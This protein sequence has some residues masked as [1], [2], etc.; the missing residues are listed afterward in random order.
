MDLFFQNNP[1]AYFLR[2]IAYYKYKRKTEKGSY[3]RI[4]FCC[5]SK[6]TFRIS[7]G[8]ICIEF[9]SKL[10]QIRFQNDFRK[11]V[12]AVFEIKNSRSKVITEREADYIISI[13]RYLPS[14]SLSNNHIR[15]SLE[16]IKKVIDEIAKKHEIAITIDE[17]NEKT[18]EI[19]NYAKERNISIFYR[20][21][22]G[23]ISESEGG[24][25]SWKLIK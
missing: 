15:D 21:R 3:M 7:L 16:K 25:I 18:E 12:N 13:S 6:K 2:F 17:S 22:E 4:E 20:N 10:Q 8:I 1:F 23:Y 14:I 19:C 5:L 11:V 24:S 9:K